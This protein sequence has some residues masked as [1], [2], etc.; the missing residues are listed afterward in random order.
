MSGRQLGE[1]VNEITRAVR[2]LYN[3]LAAFG[4]ALHADLAVTVSMRSVLEAIDRG[5]SITV[6]RVARLRS[7]SRQHIQRIVDD[8]LER[9]LV[10]L[11]T[12][13]DHKR[14]PLVSMTDEG[15][16]T[17]RTMAQRERVRLDR[18]S[19]GLSQKDLETARKILEQ[20]STRLAGMLAELG[21]AQKED[22][23]DD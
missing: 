19:G 3:Q 12:N 10:R 22:H 5:G 16:A 1:E 9:N 14:S 4:T 23:E 15:R 6:P 20:L 13:P 11:E 17:F 7:V 8:L 18:L 2:R 21:V